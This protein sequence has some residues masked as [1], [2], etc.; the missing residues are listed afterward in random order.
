MKDKLDA[1]PDDD[2]IHAVL[3]YILQTLGDDDEHKLERL[4]ALPEGLRAFFAI[5]LV[6]GEVKNGGFSQYFWN[7]GD[8]AALAAVGGFRLLGA[9]QHAALMKEAI[10][11]Q[12]QERAAMAAFEAEGTLEAF[13]ESTERS[14]LGPLDMRYYGLP[15]VEPALVRF[16]RAHPEMFDDIAAPAWTS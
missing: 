8:G 6:D 3:N 12:E 14:A 13:Q 16:I 10:A 9:E 4:N 1:L 11:I 2:L 15:D 5:W 7:N